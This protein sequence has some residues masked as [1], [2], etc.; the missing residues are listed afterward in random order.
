MAAST[1][2]AVLVGPVSIPAGV[3]RPQ[4]VVQSATNRVDID[5]FNRWSA[6][7]ADSIARVWPAISTLLGTPQV[8]TAPLANL[9]A[10][11]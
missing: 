10:Y 6:P 8:A 9:P 3:D 2:I 11:R 7:L 5:E 4:F 1:N